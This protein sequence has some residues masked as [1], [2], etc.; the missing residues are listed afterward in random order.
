MG[1][2]PKIIKNH[3]AKVFAESLTTE[4]ADAG[5]TGASAAVDELQP[6]IGTTTYRKLAGVD[7]GGQRTHH[8]ASSDRKGH[9]KSTG[10]D[11]DRD[12]AR[13]SAG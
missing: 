10:R 6:L 2:E 4:K 8:A 12:G 7:A 13:A 11:A 3:L 1:D 9:R 5:N